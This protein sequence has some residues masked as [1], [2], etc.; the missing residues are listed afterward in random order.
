MRY[1]CRSSWVYISDEVIKTVTSIPLGSTESFRGTKNNHVYRK[2]VEN[3]D[4]EI[5][6]E[7]PRLHTL[8]I[9]NVSLFVELTI[10][11]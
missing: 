6:L 7:Y 5:L 8:Q 1:L 2:R 9:M 4:R 10:Y 11:F 3:K